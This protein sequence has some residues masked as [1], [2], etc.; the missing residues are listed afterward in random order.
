MVFSKG[1]GAI[2]MQA[3]SASGFEGIAPA[4]SSVST[5]SSEH[6]IKVGMAVS[7]S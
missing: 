4:G 2:G 3:P 6:M 1:L 5:S 7:C